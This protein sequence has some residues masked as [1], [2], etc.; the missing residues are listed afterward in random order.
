MKRFFKYTLLL[1]ITVI[2]TVL[3]IDKWVKNATAKQLYTD[4]AATPYNKVGLLLGT[5]KYLR[6]GQINYYYKFRIDAAVALYKAGKVKYI[7]VSGDNRKNNYNEPEMMYQD[8]IAQGVSAVHI[9]LDYA[10]LRTLDS[11]LRCVSIFGTNK[12]TVISQQFHNERAL[13]ISNNKSLDVI[14]FNARDVNKLAGWR[15]SMR[16]KLARCK[17]LLDLMFN[18]KAKFDGP[19]IQI[20]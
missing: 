9:F 12:F 3:G 1:A 15:V 8:L 14:A 19:K 11:I 10:G 18:K 4:V 20:S 7:I 2:I 16:E 13:F 17:M 6:N 5:S